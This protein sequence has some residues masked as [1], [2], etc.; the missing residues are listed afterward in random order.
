LNMG[1]QGKGGVGKESGKTL[2]KQ[3]AVYLF[4]LGGT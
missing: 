4:S 1:V 2:E 3:K